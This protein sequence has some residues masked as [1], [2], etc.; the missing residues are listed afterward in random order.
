M[1]EGIGLSKTYKVKVKNSIFKHSVKYIEAA[2]NISMR[3]GEGEIVGLL[4]INGAGKTTTIKIMSSLLTPTSGQVLIDGIDI[5]KNLNVARKQINMI[6]GGERN[7]YWQL[8]GR[9]NLEYFGSLYYIPK[10]ILNDRIER[11]I[12]T[13]KL[14]GFIDS[15]VETYSKGM[16]QRLQIVRGMI[17]DPTIIFLDEPTIGLDV[18]V[19]KEVHEFIKL[20]KKK[21]KGIL[22]TTHYMA[23][24]EELCD[25]IHIME[26]GEII[27]SGSPRQIIES[28]IINNKV[29]V[30]TSNENILE[31]QEP[32]W[33]SAVASTFKCEIQ[34]VGRDIISYLPKAAIPHYIKKLIENGLGI[35]EIRIEN[36]K[37]EDAIIMI[38][39][40]KEN[41]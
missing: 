19:M 34:L 11:Y 18:G 16:K 39:E 23:E 14:E 15:P 13:F 2:K 7:L 3:I 9:E 30:S 26:K 22:L 20:L 32:T 5:S 41:G 6:S 38:S 25:V 36:P 8:T 24:V 4:G 27:K 28:A 21:G 40:D 1:L 31:Q 35:Q 10:K 12:D 17:N 33:I 37:L 29:I